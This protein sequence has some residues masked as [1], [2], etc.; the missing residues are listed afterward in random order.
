ML[1]FVGKK[2]AGLCLAVSAFALAVAMAPPVHAAAKS[3]KT[4]L[5]AL[6]KQIMALQAEI[7]TMKQEQAKAAVAKVTAPAPAAVSS[8]ATASSAAPAPQS[9]SVP[10]AAVLSAAPAAATPSPV[11]AAAPA[12]AGGL[13]SAIM[14]K[15]G[16]K[17]TLG[18][19]VDMTTLYRSKNQS[20][21]IA[22]NFNSLIPFNNSVNSHQSE[23][24][25][26]ARAT[27]LSLL[28]EASPDENT[29]LTA[30]IESDF[31]G[32]APTATSTVT[33]SYTPRLRQGF[34][35]YERNDLGLHVSGG[36]E[37]TLLTMHKSG[38]LPLKENAPG[39][40]D[41]GYLPGFNYAR[42]P[43]LRIVKDFMDKKLWVG[44]SAESPQAITS[45]I[46][47][48]S[49]SSSTLNCAGYNNAYLL[50]NPGNGSTYASTNSYTTDIA[51]DAIM[52]V[53]YDASW[54]HVETFGALRTFH[55]VDDARFNDN[56]VFAGGGGASVFVP[57]IEKKLDVMASFMYGYG[58]G[59][60]TVSAF[61]DFSVQPD[62][63]LQP[64]E[65]YT[66]LVGLIAKPTPSWDL[67][68]YAGVEEA[69]RNNIDGQTSNAFGY[70][71]RGVSNTGCYT[72]GGTCYA[73]TK[74]VWQ[75]TPG[76][77]TRLYDGSYG[78]V[79][80]GAQY[81]LT[82]RDAFSDVSGN[83]PHSYQHMVLTS[84]RYHPF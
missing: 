40:V 52:K 60:Y 65:E 28:G 76:F 30:Y 63:S 38:M 75:V 78:K 22:S 45:G 21:D 27:R 64:L 74:R 79:Q 13:Q 12:P 17:L 42:T 56:V 77:W 48:S 32:A 7:Q 3:E 46:C 34:A 2:K 71:N 62:G 47:T 70:G 24:R 81:S 10:M 80:V 55:N 8:F 15:T 6:Q 39:T 1:S 19:Q 59:R 61:P 57:A 73:Q 23:F 49:T 9:A 83:A 82:R 53:A 37:W 29:K 25:G 67:F 68:L 51:P 44:V 20:S 5:E 36:Q 31:L 18:G 54:G 33:N 16:V 50:N 11:A 66:A 4:T 43:Q 72:E 58:M 69:F 41:A 35:Q 14:S 84:F 26:S